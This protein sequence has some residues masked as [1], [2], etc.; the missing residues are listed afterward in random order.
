MCQLEL[1]Q[2]NVYHATSP[3]VVNMENWVTLLLYTRGCHRKPVCRLA[4]GMGS[5][6]ER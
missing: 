3:V 2:P 4:L 1:T 5:Y 6:P